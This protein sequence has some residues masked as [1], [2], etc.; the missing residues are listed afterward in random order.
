MSL[1]SKPAVGRSRR[2]S[3]LTYANVISTVALFLALAGGS[4]YAANH[5][6]INNTKQIKPS[7]L[8]A[9]KGKAGAQG[10]QGIQG[11][12][13]P[14]TGTAGG[15]LAGSY[16]NPTFANASVT[17]S[18]L[19]AN[20]N[21]N[22]VDGRKLECPSGTVEEVG[23]CIETSDRTAA[24]LTVAADDCA[25]AGG[26]LP[27]ALSLYAVSTAAALNINASEWTD[28]IYFDH[29]LSEVVGDTINSGV[30]AVDVPYSDA[31]V[32]RCAYTLVR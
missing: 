11:P 14:S 9:L 16:P 7:V 31:H 24:E 15:V 4:A 29:T 27:P 28:E 5:Y 22:E 30:I 8:K 3:K 18:A 20:L 23:I 17:Q 10:A 1:R 32:Y 26:F 12:V 25:A 19:A 13:G 2:S 6:L 21:V